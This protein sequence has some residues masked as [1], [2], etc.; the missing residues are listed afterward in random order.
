VRTN[1]QSGLNVFELTAFIL[2]VGMGC[3]VSSVLGNKFGWV[4]YVFGFLLGAAIGFACVYGLFYGLAYLFDNFFPDNSSVPFCKNGKCKEGHYE[5]HKIEVSKE[6]HRA[7]WV[8]RCGGRY[9][10]SGRCFYEVLPDG[11]LQPYMKWKPF[12]GWLPDKFR[13]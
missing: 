5:I 13:K 7:D 10:K 6:K 9:H 2:W 8:C 1:S 4:G 11:S 12:R 3:L